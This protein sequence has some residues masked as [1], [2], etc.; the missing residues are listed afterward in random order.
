[1]V[2]PVPLRAEFGVAVR[3]APTS[4]GWN[5]GRRARALLGNQGRKR[6]VSAIE[7]GNEALNP[8]LAQKF[9]RVLGLPAPLQEW[10]LRQH[11]PEGDK[12]PDATERRPGDLR[13]ATGDLARR[14]KKSQAMAVVLAC[15]VAQVTTELG[16]AR[17]DFRRALNLAVSGRES[18][19]A[20]STR[21][22]IR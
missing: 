17:K 7:R 15:E 9:D 11:L 8:R 14:L 18:R 5:L 2:T 12:Q 20:T 22:S 1:M 19:A 6:H 16:G 13:A 10:M 21:A 3:E 4:K